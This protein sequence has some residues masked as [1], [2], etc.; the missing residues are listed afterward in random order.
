[1]TRREF[2]KHTAKLIFIFDFYPE[3]EWKEQFEF[4]A[5]YSEIK[6]AD[7]ESL[8][9]RIMALE[10]KKAEVDSLIDGASKKWSVAPA[11]GRSRASLRRAVLRRISLYFRG[12][13]DVA[14][15]WATPLRISRAPVLTSVR[16]S[17]GGP[18]PLLR[19]LY[20]IRFPAHPRQERP[21]RLE[22]L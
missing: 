9:Q 4:Y 1:M 10:E 6:E 14:A 8:W 12:R 17:I 19:G 16:A 15:R 13:R 11:P 5:D 7:R 20:G 3:A 18:V 2:K 22:A 21:R